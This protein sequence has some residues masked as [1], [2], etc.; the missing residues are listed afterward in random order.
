MT[1]RCA[2]FV[3]PHRTPSYMSIL[4]MPAHRNQPTRN[5]TIPYKKGKSAPAAPAFLRGAVVCRLAKRDAGA[6]SDGRLCAV[7][8][9]EGLA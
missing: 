2:L 6:G 9:V 7:A 4:E 5:P 1:I 3:R 8:A